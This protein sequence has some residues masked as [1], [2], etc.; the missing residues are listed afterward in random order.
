[1]NHILKH[2]QIT[3]EELKDTYGY[4]HPPR[5]ARDVRECGIPLDT[6][7]VRGSDG[8]MIGAYKF[9]DPS[10]IERHK[11]GGRKTFS[12]AF[13]QLLL[14]RQGAR[15]AS[16]VRTGWRRKTRR[17]AANVIGLGLRTTST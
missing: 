8:R 5:A 4:N 3:T 16:T 9:G 13:K 15:C 6:I 14:E 12:K 17:S 11:L 7:R 1:M 2:G 10:K